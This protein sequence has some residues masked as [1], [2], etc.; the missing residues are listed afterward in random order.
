[1]RPSQHGV[2][3]RFLTGQ[4]GSVTAEFAIALPSVVLVLAF[5]LA[6]IQLASQQ[7][8]VQDAAALTA[9]SIA[10]DDEPSASAAGRLVPGLAITRWTLGELECVTAT[11]PAAGGPIGLLGLELRASSCALGGG[12]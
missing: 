10:R 1:M 12:R 6:A 2:D 4:S 7:I 3:R 5:C 8:R 11:A 9:R